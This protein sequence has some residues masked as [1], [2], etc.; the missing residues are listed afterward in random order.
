[1]NKK[2]FALAQLAPY[3]KDKNKCG[4]E[5]GACVYLTRTGNSCVAGANMIKP[6]RWGGRGISTILREHTQEEVFKPESVGIL[7]N[8]EWASLQLIHD[9]IATSSPHLIQRNVCELRL[10]SM[11]ELEEAANKLQ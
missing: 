5:N 8:D 7:T 1:M 6:S 11:S 2:E 3:Y 10:F 4:F 9:S